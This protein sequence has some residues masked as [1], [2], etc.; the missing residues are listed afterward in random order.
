MLLPELSCIM[1]KDRWIPGGRK[2]DKDRVGRTEDMDHSENGNYKSFEARKRRAKRAII[3]LAVLI[4]LAGL[5]AG[6][7]YLYE[8]ENKVYNDYETVSVKEKS[9][10]AAEYTRYRSGAM[11]VSR[12]GAEAFDEDGNLLWNVS[13]TMNDPIYEVC[14]KAAAVADRAGRSLYIMDG[15]GSSNPVETLHQIYAIDVANQGVTAVLMTDGADTY[16]DLFDIKGTKLV[17]IKSN[18]N[19]QGFP[20]D[21][22]LSNDGRKLITS[23]LIMKDERMTTQITCYNFDEVGQN[24]TERIVGVYYYE[25]KFCPKVEFVNNNTFCVFLDDGMKVFR[26]EE[27]PKEPIFEKEFAQEI[28]SVFYN[29]SYIGLVLACEDGSAR[30]QMEVYDLAGNQVLAKDLNDKYTEILVTEDEIIYYD[31]LNVVI[32]KLNGMEKFRYQFSTNIDFFF[33]GGSSRKYLMAADEEIRMI[34]LSQ[35]KEETK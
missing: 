14:E 15:T 23:Y 9:S 33:P 30:Y 11:R 7:L 8:Q 32:T 10:G 24:Y 19:E 18:A 17:E 35:K 16:I 1:E 31:N 26:M 34:E 2:S 22:A 25:Q 12:D 20:V 28:E 21:I 3:T 29:E 6:L 4:L 13:Y 5:A 27:I